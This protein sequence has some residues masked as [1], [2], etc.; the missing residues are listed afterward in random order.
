M[1]DR[2]GFHRRRGG[3]AQP[4]F[5]RFGVLGALAQRCSDPP[6]GGPIRVPASQTLKPGRRLDEAVAAVAA[7]DALAAGVFPDPHLRAGATFRPWVRDFRSG[8]CQPMPARGQ[9]G[10]HRVGGSHPPS[11]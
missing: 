6:V 1:D 2:G 10:L 8:H 9:E 7:R 4:Q 5:T 3:G 11:R